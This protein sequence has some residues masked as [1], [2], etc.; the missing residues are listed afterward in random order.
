MKDDMSAIRIATI[1]NVLNNFD[2]VIVKKESTET[3]IVLT[4]ER[5]L[6]VLDPA[7]KEPKS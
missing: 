5:L 6:T 7:A 3:K 4:I 2:W 1:E